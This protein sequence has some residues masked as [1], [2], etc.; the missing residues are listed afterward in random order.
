MHSKNNYNS[1]DLFALI[2]AMI[3][4]VALHFVDWIMCVCAN[5]HALEFEIDIDHLWHRNF[6]AGR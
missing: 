2:G 5:V 1:Q 3:Q 4:F 6:E